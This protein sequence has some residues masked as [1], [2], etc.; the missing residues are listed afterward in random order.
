MRGESGQ[1]ECTVRKSD[2]KENVNMQKHRGSPC[3]EDGVQGKGR[4]W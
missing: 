1:R 4:D 3:E 2:G